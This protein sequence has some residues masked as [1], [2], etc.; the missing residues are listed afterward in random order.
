MMG[1]IMKPKRTEITQKLREEINKVVNKYIAQGICE[2]NPGIYILLFL[3]LLNISGVLFIDEVHMLDIEC[4]TYLNKALES[5]LAPIVIL[6]TN[7]GNTYIRGSYDQRQYSYLLGTNILSPHG[8][9]LDL[10]DRLLIIRTQ[11]YKLEHIQFILKIRAE[12][13][14]IKITD[15]ALQRL[16]E[17]GM[18]TSLR[19]AVQLLSPANVLSQTIEADNPVV[20]LDMIQDVSTLFLSAKDSAELVKGEGFITH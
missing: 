12:T 17:I 9:P 3:C 18:D 2:V 19:H 15:E 8:I 5:T 10:L 13:E 11:P 16:S 7:R 1:N 6:A 4:F 20:T 14:G